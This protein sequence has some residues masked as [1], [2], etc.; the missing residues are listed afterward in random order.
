[1]RHE[2]LD[3]TAILCLCGCG[4]TVVQKR[5]DQ[6]FYSRAC[7]QRDYSKTNPVTR[8]KAACKRVTTLA[9]RRNE[10]NGSGRLAGGDALFGR[11][12]PVSGFEDRPVA[13]HGKLRTRRRRSED[14]RSWRKGQKRANELPSGYRNRYASLGD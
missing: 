1:M 14:S 11:L 8:R 4:R 2:G 6:K 10:K 12:E 9:V 7:R 5:H 3:K 13:L